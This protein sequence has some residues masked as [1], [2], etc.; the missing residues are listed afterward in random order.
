MKVFEVKILKLAARLTSGCRSV[1]LA[2]HI[3]TCTCRKVCTC[4]LYYT[5]GN[6]KCAVKYCISKVVT[7]GWTDI[8]DQIFAP[9][10]KG[11]CIHC[12]VA[13]K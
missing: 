4:R 1:W 7:V 12:S 8:S 3:Y 2:H 11:W 5:E 10:V 9:M 13:G 6:D